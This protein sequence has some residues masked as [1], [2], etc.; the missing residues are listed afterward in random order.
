MQP[1]PR[2]PLSE[3]QR[4]ASARI[5]TARPVGRARADE[6][7]Q[8]R[9][10][11]SP[12]MHPDELPQFGLK[13]NAPYPERRPAS[14]QSPRASPRMTSPRAARLTTARVCPSQGY[15]PAGFQKPWGGLPAGKRLP[16]MQYGAQ[17]S[18]KARPT[19]AHAANRAPAEFH[20]AEMKR[21]VDAAN[22]DGVLD[23]VERRA[24]T[25][26]RERELEWTKYTPEQLAAINKSRTLA[27]D[28][29]HRK[30][31]SAYFFS[32][33]VLCPTDTSFKLR[34]GDNRPSWHSIW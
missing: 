33:T 28:V 1:S 14:V 10:S 22:A 11:V 27:S 31:P 21:V 8:E 25:T 16:W 3:R 19:S 9:F 24:L 12:R 15:E 20:K 29:F 4:P 2:A 6:I 23:D 5:G 18:I 34:P 26:A 32:E 7:R 30:P 13:Y 17:C